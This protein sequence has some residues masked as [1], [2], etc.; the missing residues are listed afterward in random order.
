MNSAEWLRRG[1]LLISR[2][3][4]REHYHALNQAA[5]PLIPLFR[6]PEP[7]L[8]DTL[9]TKLIEHLGYAAEYYN[10]GAPTLTFERVAITEEQ[11]EDHGL[12][13]KPVKA[14]QSRKRYDIDQTVEAE[15]M[16]PAMLREIVAG[17][18]EPMVD[19]R[20]MMLLREVEAAERNDLRERLAEFA[21]G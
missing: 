1:R 20:Q 7:L 9:E 16:P 15:A 17:A 4:L 13:T 5:I 18:F 3:C 8:A 2:S 11:I 19:Q 6:F 12:P 10:A 21:E 14:T